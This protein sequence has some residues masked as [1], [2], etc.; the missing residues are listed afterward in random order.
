MHTYKRNARIAGGLFILATVL[1]IVGGSLLLPLDE[2]AYLTGAASA[3]SQIVLG[4]LLEIVMAVSVVGIAVM[5][6]P[7]LRRQ[8]E[9]LGLGYVGA[10]VLEAVLLGAAAISSLVI[11]TLGVEFGGEA[12]GLGDLML[13][14]RDWTYL[15]GSL[16]FLGLGGLVLYTL[17]Y[18]S[19]VVPAWLSVW[20]LLAAVLIMARG[21]LEAFGVELSGVVQGVLAAPIAIQEMVL[22]VWLIV[23]GFDM[24]AFMDR[25]AEKKVL[26][27]V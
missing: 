13:T 10:R 24:S 9:G 4:A 19:R 6:F 22:A 12:Q 23:K 16:V 20:G 11:L 21:L 15:L 14:V 5:L 3:E 25:T 26:T 27:S 18:Q 1:A 2:P 17:L 7:V 8:D